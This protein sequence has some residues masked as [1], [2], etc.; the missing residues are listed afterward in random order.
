MARLRRGRKGAPPLDAVGAGAQGHG[1][2]FLIVSPIPSH[3][4]DQG[5]SARIHLLGRSL[6]RPGARVHFLYHPMEGLHPT[7]RQAMERCW[8]ALHVVP[9]TRMD[10]SGHGLDDWYENEVGR[11]AAALQ[12]RHGY[13]AVI[14]NYVWFSGVLNAFGADVLKILDTHDVF[15][16]RDARFIA[17]GLPPEW[18]WTTPAEEAR[19][20]ARADIVLAI[21]HEEASVFRALGHGDVRVVGHLPPWRERAPRGDGGLLNIGYLASANPINAE[22]FRALRACLPSGGIAGARLL[23]AGSLC[24]RLGDVAPWEALGRVEST[25]AFY[26]QVDV[27]VNPMTFGTGLKIKSVEAMFEDV[28]LV[29]TAEAMKGLPAKHALHRLGDVAAVARALPEVVA[30]AGLRRALILAG[31]QAAREYARATQASQDAL[32]ATMR[33]WA[34]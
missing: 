24:D 4:Q 6:Q 12:A 28:P 33:A 14:A 25:G 1:L 3:P 15:G 30:N 26:D 9:V 27:V 21:Q 8:D 10:L 11:V 13:C 29:A 19:G 20:L 7:Q 22:S 34:G 32:W 23:V 18:Y 16:D 5:N 2:T 31:R 17:A